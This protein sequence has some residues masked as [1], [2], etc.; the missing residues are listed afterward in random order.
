[1]RIGEGMLRE[2]DERSARGHGISAAEIVAALD[3]AF[4]GNDHAK[5]ALAQAVAY[6]QARFE[7]V[8]DGID[9]EHLPPKQSVLIGGPTGSGK[10]AITKAV[11]SL[12]NVPYVVVSGASMIGTGYVGTTVEDV[13]ASLVQAAGG[14]LSQAER[15]IVLIDEVDKIRRRRFGKQDDVAGVSVQH[16]WLTVL[17]GTSPVALKPVEQGKRLQTS[18]ITF[19]ATGVFKGLERR[20]RR[21]NGE[22]ATL[23]DAHEL[24]KLG[25]LDEFIGRFSSRIW[26]HPPTVDVLKR[27]LRLGKG[28]V[29]Q[30][31]NLFAVLGLELDFTDEALEVIAT[32]A[33][34]GGTG[35]RALPEMIHRFLSPALGMVDRWKQDGTTRIVVDREVIYGAEPMATEPTSPHMSSDQAIEA[36]QAQSSGLSNTSDHFQMEY[37]RNLKVL[38]LSAVSDRVKFWWESF[39]K[40]YAANRQVMLKLTQELVRH[41]ATIEEFYWAYCRSKTDNIMGVIGL[42]LYLRNVSDAELGTRQRANSDSQARRVRSGELLKLSGW[43]RFD[44]FDDDGS[45][46]VPS[47]MR[48]VI[49][50]SAG[51][52]APLAD[53]RP[54]FWRL[55]IPR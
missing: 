6:N 27:V 47:S 37:E 52:V 2:G 35:V 50:L 9:P 7:L 23:I 25:F 20:R 18:G 33:A 12:A 39:E 40:M 13:V 51:E 15:G 49:R 46:P 42:M 38:K 43:Y 48:K 26:L 55:L 41:R 4:V 45:G 22:F 30:W 10:S 28:P 21:P 34:G 24:V 16:A 14:D 32:E 54:A 53:G 11:A 19:I 44:D 17:E 1:M 3:E 5:A 29:Q 8:A 31:K 36:L